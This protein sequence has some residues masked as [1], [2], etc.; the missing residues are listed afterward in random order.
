MA[1]LNGTV[2]TACTWRITRISGVIRQRDPF[3]HGDFG[4]WM[5]DATDGHVERHRRH[6]LHKA[7]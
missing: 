7:S 3:L 6:R 2:G 5:T 4:S 1:M